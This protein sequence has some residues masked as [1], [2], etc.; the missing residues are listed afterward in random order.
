MKKALLL[1]AAVAVSTISFAQSTISFSYNGNTYTE[2]DTVVFTTEE[3]DPAVLIPHLT[4]LDSNTDS[5]QASCYPCAGTTGME[6]IS[7]CAGRCLAGNVSPVFP[8]NADGSYND[9]MVDF[10]ITTGH[11]G[12][13]KYQ[14]YK[15]GVEG[16]TLTLIIKVVYAP[17]SI[18]SVEESM[19]ELS[20][21]PN[22]AVSNVKVDVILPEGANNAMVVLRDLAGRTLRQQ[23]VAQNGMVTLNVEGLAHGVYMCGILTNDRL[24]AVKKVVV[25]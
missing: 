22:P 12:F 2:G 15:T 19:G 3:S 5:A 1:I 14:V 17:V 9:M 20:I 8:F 13:F 10:H 6:V 4:N 16:D 25:L 23:A 24:A 21:Y 18:A 7:L 11:E